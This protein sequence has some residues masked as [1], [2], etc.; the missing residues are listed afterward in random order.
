MPGTPHETITQLDEAFN[1]G[2]LEA[3]LNF[4]EE[5]AAMVLEP[6][7]LA[8][9]K[10]ELRRAYEWILANMKG[11]ATQEKTHIIETGDLALFTSQ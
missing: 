1:R 7:R 10:A 3:I 11:I 8:T 2:E 9:G 6:G 4:Y 5:G